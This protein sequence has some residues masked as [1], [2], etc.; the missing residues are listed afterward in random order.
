MA[1]I[2]PAATPAIDR[3]EATR[4]LSLVKH[5]IAEV[6]ADA[7]RKRPFYAP[8]VREAEAKAKAALKALDEFAASLNRIKM[9][10]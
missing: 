4:V 1:D 5:E 6:V 2:K 3:A 8:S 10:A 9:T 7:H